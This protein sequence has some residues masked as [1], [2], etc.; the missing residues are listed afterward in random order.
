MLALPSSSL[1]FF[2]VMISPPHSDYHIL[3]LSNADN[4]H[5]LGV[6]NHI[7]LTTWSA[8]YFRS[9]IVF[10]IT[11]SNLF[12]FKGRGIDTKKVMWYR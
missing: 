6:F 10:I 7:L 4:N 11:T 2:L 1:L 5:A 8:F 9:I 12:V 3:F